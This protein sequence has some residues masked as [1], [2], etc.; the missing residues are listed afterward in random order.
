MPFAHP[1]CLEYS[2]HPAFYELESLKGDLPVLA[3]FN[4]IASLLCLV[5]EPPRHRKAATGIWERLACVFLIT[6]GKPSRGSWPA[7][8]RV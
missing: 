4:F 2:T 6:R 5:T 1:S 8:L 7:E 3:G